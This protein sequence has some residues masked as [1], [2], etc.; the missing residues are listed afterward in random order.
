MVSS[1][2]LYWSPIS[3][4][5]WTD[6]KSS[7][8]KKREIS[9]TGMNLGSVFHYRVKKSSEESTMSKILKLMDN[10]LQQK[11]QFQERLNFFAR[12]FNF[13]ALILK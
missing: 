7:S 11:T 8:P 2:A 5:G 10:A 13:D 3:K 6:P 1:I 9:I 12:H 4:L